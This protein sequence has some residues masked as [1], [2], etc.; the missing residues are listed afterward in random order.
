[1]EHIGN[2]CVVLCRVEPCVVMRE[3]RISTRL[4]SPGNRKETSG[5]AKEMRIAEDQNKRLL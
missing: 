1:M 4:Q 2:M 3:V 5:S